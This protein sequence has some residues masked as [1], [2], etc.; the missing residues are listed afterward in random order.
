M[1]LAWNTVPPGL[2]LALGGNCFVQL[3][4]G[5]KTLLGLISKLVEPLNLTTLKN[6]LKEAL[7]KLDALALVVGKGAISQ[8]STRKGSNCTESSEAVFAQG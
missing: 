4:L 1:P 2:I 5:E 6:G 7:E 3:R 8:N